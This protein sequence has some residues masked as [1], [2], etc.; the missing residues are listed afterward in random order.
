MF[1]LWYLADQSASDEFGINGAKTFTGVFTSLADAQAKAVSD[2]VAHYS[3]E[4][5][6]DAGGIFCIVFIV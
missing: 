1:K 4:Q 2:G 3:V 5:S 6:Q